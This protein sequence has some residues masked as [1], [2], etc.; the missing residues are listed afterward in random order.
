M[1]ILSKMRNI[2]LE[3]IILGSIILKNSLWIHIEEE[4]IEKDHFYENR[5]KELFAI[6]EKL[7]KDNEVI[8][9]VT[10]NN[11]IL[12]KGIEN[13]ISISFLST[14]ITNVIST[15]NF[16]TYLK[17]L[18]KYKEKRDIKDI[19][20]YIQSNFH[21]ESEELKEEL[22][23]RILNITKEDKKDSGSIR[24]GMDKLLD[25]L[26]FRI[27]NRG[28]D[29]ISG[30]S[31]G[32]R[33]LDLTIDGFEKGDLITVVARSGIGKTTFATSL[34]L[35]MLRKDY[36][37]AMF[38]MEMPKEHILKKMAF[39]HCRVEGDKY[40][41]GELR[42]EEIQNIVEFVN[43]I[44]GRENFFIYNDSNFNSIVWK[45]KS[46]L[47]KKKV[48]IVF[49]DYLN[50]IQG[51][52]ENTRDIELNRVTSTL[53]DIALENNI[54]I[55]SLTQAN[56]QVDRQQDKRIDLAD[57]KESSSIEQNSDKVISLYRNKK[58]DNPL[59]KEKLFNEGKLNYKKPNA[60]YNPDC[61][62]VDVLKCRM[63]DCKTIACRWSGKHSK[64]SN[65]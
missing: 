25:D 47:L 10:L 5:H 26:E 65:W 15:S 44:G 11:Y 36:K 17:E 22:T 38:S 64:I 16:Q 53:K 14:L 9:M 63:G 13:K 8:D 60:D 48:D 57:I 46:Q 4:N 56:R 18:K 23:K 33:A 28:Q 7:I 27:T 37:V 29:K 20:I 42:D 58:L 54:C 61:I 31:T 43:W 55:V 41:R 34:I 32:L 30:F 6:M 1:D 12:K 21:K 45:I 24:E 62:E 49:I 39:N 2:E 52:K 59:Y 50:K 40:K 51:L 35:N 19:M 3:Q